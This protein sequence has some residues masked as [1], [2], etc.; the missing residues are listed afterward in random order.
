[1]HLQQ[2]LNLTPIAPGMAR[3]SLDR[4]AGTLRQDRLDDLRLIVSE[5]VTNCI[6]HSGLRGDDSIEMKVE[7]AGHGIR[8]EVSD[9]GVG[10]PQERSGP[11][12]ESGWGLGIVERLAD[13]WGYESGPRTKVWAELP[14][15]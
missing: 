14:L 9:P 2:R 11:R 3:R 4:F 13:R 5:L 1:M 6:R 12:S 8:V 15:S 7:L 10:F